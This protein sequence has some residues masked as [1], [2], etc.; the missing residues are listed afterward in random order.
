MDSNTG[1]NFDDE[2]HEDL[3]LS[4]EADDAESSTGAGVGPS[5]AERAKDISSHYLHRSWPSQYEAG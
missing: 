1:L 4:E 5:L 2:E 3:G